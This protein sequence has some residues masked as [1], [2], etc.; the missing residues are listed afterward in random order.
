M[1]EPIRTAA[2]TRAPAR[3]KE[4]LMRPLREQL[5]RGLSPRELSVTVS[6]GAVLGVFPI[7]GSTTALCFLAAWA[8]RLNHPVIQ[9]AN[10]LVA[11]VQPALILLFVRLG[12]RALR[13]EPV[14]FDP[15]ELIEDF[16]ASPT[17]F[18]AR[19]GMTG[20]HGILGW[21]MV[22]VPLGAACAALLEPAL[23]NL[24]FRLKGEA[25]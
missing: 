8:F 2:P 13:A 12:E 3:W 23:R 10:W 16:T 6:L 9:A 5:R 14:P 15:R 21:A 1:N 22:A 4:N 11:W 19:F 7:L 20:L 25:S 18:L 24:G 17:A